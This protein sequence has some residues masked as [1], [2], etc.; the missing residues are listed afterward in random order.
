MRRGLVEV[1]G[2]LH[3]EE[4]KTSASRRTVAIPAWLGEELAFHLAGHDTQYV[5]TA[6]RGGPLRR[7]G[8]RFR[9]WVPATVRADLEGL[10]FHDL[11]HTHAAWLVGAGEHPKVIQ[12]RLGHASISTTLDRY[13][14]LMDG[15]ERP[16]RRR[17][18]DFPR[19]LRA[20]KSLNFVRRSCRGA[21]KPPL[22]RVFMLWALL[23]L[24]QWPL[25][26]EGSALPLS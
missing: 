12:A 16:P 2:R 13:G 14:H 22:T 5:F 21:T 25:P 1:S 24:N 8:F 10:R 11:R 18:R 26:C 3:V 7:S 23:G 20:L 15:L 4:P 19:T 9:V 6:P 17:C